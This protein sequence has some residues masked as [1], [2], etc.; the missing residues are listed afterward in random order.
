M[1]VRSPLLDLGFVRFGIVGVAATFIHVAVFSLLVEVFGVAPVAASVPA[2]VTAMFASYGVNHRWT[3]GAQGSHRV[4]LPR[5]AVVALTGLG[6]NVLITY[7]VVNLLGYWYGLALAV[8]VTVV[9]AA[10]FLLNRNWAFKIAPA[11]AKPGTRQ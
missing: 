8:V 3:F 11:S 9:P 10:T 1:S 7:V 6:L 4:H 2:F 5:Y